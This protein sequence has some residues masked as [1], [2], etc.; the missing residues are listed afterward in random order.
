MLQHY[1]RAVVPRYYNGGVTKAT[2]GT[3]SSQPSATDCHKESTIKGSIKDSRGY[4]NESII[5]AQ[6]R[7]Y[8]TIIKRSSRNRETIKDSQDGQNEPI[9]KSLSRIRHLR[10]SHQYSMICVN[11]N[12]ELI[13]TMLTFRAKRPLTRR[14]RFTLESN[15][16]ASHTKAMPTDATLPVGQ[17]LG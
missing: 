5:K 4:H 3:G 16:R 7:I 12:I 10:T 2:Q 15:R 1:S 6:L 8:E 13:R 9:M 17:Y 11:A 14:Q